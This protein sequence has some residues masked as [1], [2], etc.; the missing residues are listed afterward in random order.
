MLLQ[1]DEPTVCAGEAGKASKLPLSLLGNPPNSGPE[2]RQ[3]TRQFTRHTRTNEITRISLKTISRGIAVST[4]LWTPCNTESHPGI[5]PKSLCTAGFAG[6]RPSGFEGRV[7]V[8]DSPE[9]EMSWSRPLNAKGGAEKS[10]GAGTLATSF[11]PCRNRPI[12][13]PASAP[14]GRRCAAFSAARKA[15]YQHRFLGGRSFSSDIK[16]SAQRLPL[17]ASFPRAFHSAQPSRARKEAA[18]NSCNQH[19]TLSQ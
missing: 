8:H 11:P 19:R 2:M 14:E 16:S 9:S 5:S 7:F 6:V 18:L 13:E 17:A 15:G 4:L 12:I 3:K 1:G 10:S